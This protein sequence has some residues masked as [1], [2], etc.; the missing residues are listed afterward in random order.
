MKIEFILK[1]LVL[2]SP[3][4]VRRFLDHVSFY[5]RFIEHITRIVNTFFK[6]H[7]KD[8]NFSWDEYCQTT[9]DNLKEKK[10]PRKPS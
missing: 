4:D 7:N 5:I 3:K 10:L 6:L 8:T 9:F 1:L 2:K